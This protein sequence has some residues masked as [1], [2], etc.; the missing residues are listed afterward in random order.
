MSSASLPC[1]VCR[2]V[3]DDA[4]TEQD[5]NQPADATTFTSH[6]GYGSTVYDPMTERERLEVNVCDDCLVS[7]A[8]DGAVLHVS[9][10]PVPARTSITPWAPDVVPAGVPL[11]VQPT[12]E[13]RRALGSAVMARRLWLDE[14]GHD[15]TAL[16]EQAAEHLRLVVFGSVLLVFTDALADT[17]DELLRWPAGTTGNVLAGGPPPAPDTAI[18]DRT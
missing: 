14:Q 5:H 11:P 13:V 12:Q 10:T 6:G 17:L 9:V 7:A 1:I 15:S 8:R 18:A 3:L 4:F 2:R 16:S